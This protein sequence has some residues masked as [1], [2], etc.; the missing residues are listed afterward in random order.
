MA[1]AEKI[2]LP[3]AKL[4]LGITIKLPISWKHHP[5][6]FN[7]IKIKEEAQIELIKSLGISY[8]I[9][10]SGHELIP[11][12]EE[13]IEEVQEVVDETPQI[14][15]KSQARKAL[16]VSQQR[17]IQN[18][19]DSRTAFSKTSSD[20]EGAYHSAMAIVKGM[21]EHMSEVDRPELALVSAGES[22]TSITQHGI[23]VAV[24]ALMMAKVLGMS[25]SDMSDIALGC[26]YH[27][28]GK[29][30]VPENIRTKKGPLSDT[31]AN[32]M[33][34][35]PNFGYDMLSK[36][37]L[38]PES[39][40]NIVRHH[41][42]FIDGSGYPDGLTADNIPMLTQ[43]VSLANDFDSQLWAESIRSP[44]VALGFLFKK[45]AGKHD[46]SLVASLVKTLGIY[47]PGTIVMLSDGNVAK[48]MMTTR[49]VKQPQVWVCDPDGSNS[50][51]KLLIED[52]VTI[53]QVIKI[54]ELSEGAMKT[55]QPEMGI[56]FYF[57][58]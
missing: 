38:F 55:L 45:R 43:I 52:N 16:K 22:D 24:V 29:L 57:N 33:K 31:E 19:N 27:D 12:D 20:P 40:L 50:G 47:P 4:Q 11:E 2:H 1:R 14:D 32:F 48:V 10:V 17:F 8:V 13:E 30:K 3:L 36:S 9:L 7:R 34:T 54:E 23:S 58:S 28:I 25:E 51:L 44:Q 5:F 42:E 56:S 18:V 46:D 35:H 21:M 26:L 49:E 37:G 39:V 53:E 41:H 6:L 15:T